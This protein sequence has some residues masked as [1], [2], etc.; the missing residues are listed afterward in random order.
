MESMNTSCVL[1]T[2]AIR[3]K[4]GYGYLLVKRKFVLAH[5]YVYEQAT[6]ES[7]EGLHLHHRCH[8]KA[9]VEVTHLEPLTNAEHRHQHTKTHCKFGHEYTPS[10]TYLN[11]KTGGRSCR[12]CRQHR[13]RKQLIP[14]P[15]T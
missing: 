3:K 2:G 13:N 9:C 4:D 5:R 7:L 14:M 1:W 6:G 11:P 15:N 12:T 8:T 10:T